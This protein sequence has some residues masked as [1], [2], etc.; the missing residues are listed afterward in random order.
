MNGIIGMTQ[1]VLGTELTG[2]QREYLAMV[3]TSAESLLQVIN[4]ILDFSRIEADKLTIERA[5]FGLRNLL[6]DV[7][8]PPGVRAGEGPRAGAAGR[9]WRAR[10]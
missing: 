10:R 6:A 2:S 8:C 5:P 7:V 4:D 3:Q 9:H 1:L